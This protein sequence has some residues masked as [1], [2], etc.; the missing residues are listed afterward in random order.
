MV[1]TDIR[2]KMATA[3]LCINLFL[4]NGEMSHQEEKAKSLKYLSLFKV[5]IPRLLMWLRPF[6]YL[7]LPQS[8][9]YGIKQNIVEKGKGE[10][11]F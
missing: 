9:Y 8:T 1:E 4:T 10:R 5:P 2:R 11:Y 6:F 7:E 3:I